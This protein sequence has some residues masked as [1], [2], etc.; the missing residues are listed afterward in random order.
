MNHPQY[1]HVHNW[2]KHQTYR[3]DRG[4]PPWIK[5]HRNLFLSPKWAHLSDAQKGHLVS[6][7]ILAADRD[8]LIPGDPAIIQKLCSLDRTPDL[9][10][11]ISLG[12]IERDAKVT[13][14]RRQVDAPEERRGEERQRREEGEKRPHTK[15]QIRFAESL[16]KVHGL[17]IGT[18]M[19][20][21][22]ETFGAASIPVTVRD[23]DEIVAEFKGKTPAI[24]ARA[25]ASFPDDPPMTFEE[26][27]AAKIALE[28]MK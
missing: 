8:G 5:V 24:G 6:I 10:V 14:T 1:L 15:K 26:R 23:I 17:T 28:G 25:P 21:C 16:L 27:E 13:P 4:Q 18:W 12:L 19:K 11:L 9:D 2:D 20:G 3:R 22:G 7:W